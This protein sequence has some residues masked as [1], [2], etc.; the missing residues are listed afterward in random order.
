MVTPVML[1]PGRFRLATSP[2]STGSNPAVKTIGIVVVAVATVWD[3]YWHQTHPM[4]VGT[5]MAALP[6]HQAILAGF[7]IGLVGAVYGAVAELREPI[8][9][10]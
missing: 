3:L 4:E 9:I 6:P 1:P 2:T 7:L 8:A 10:P 5:S